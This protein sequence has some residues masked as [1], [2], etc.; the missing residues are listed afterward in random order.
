MSGRRRPQRLS[1]RGRG[2]INPE[3]LR[4][5]IWALIEEVRGRVADLRRTLAERRQIIRSLA[6]HRGG[7]WDAGAD[8]RPDEPGAGTPEPGI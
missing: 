4:D 2:E 1:R 7:P 8:P 5:E 6:A 3:A